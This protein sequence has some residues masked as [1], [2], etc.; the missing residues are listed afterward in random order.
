MFKLFP[1]CPACHSTHFIAF[2]KKDLYRCNRCGHLMRISARR[3]LGMLLDKGSFKPMAEPLVTTDPLVFPDYHDKLL[4][5]RKRT[6]LGDAIIAGTGRI[7]GMDLAL[8]IL[9]SHFIM[10]SM[11]AYVGEAICQLI[12]LAIERRYPVVITICSGGARMQE[13]IISLMQMAKTA[14]SI[15]Q[16]QDHRLP[17]FAVLTDPTTG[18]VTASF[19]MLADVIIA[20]K[21]SLIGFAGPRVIAQT[22]GQDLP[23][24]FQKAEF[25]LE[26]GMVDMVLDRHEI[27][28]ALEN[29]LMLHKTRP[30]F[31]Q[32][33]PYE[34]RS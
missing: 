28:A 8:A 30:Y 23:Q 11:G 7:A 19:A 21:G 25:L 17:Y 26:H 20:E 15:A 18:G 9:D 3:R 14:A 22:I 32:R 12:D 24:G 5:A 29:L 4:E 13:G 10:A 31:H 2:L 33:S 1:S 16:L 27:R 34:R 6:G